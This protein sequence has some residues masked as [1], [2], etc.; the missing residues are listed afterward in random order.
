MTNLETHQSISVTGIFNECIRSFTER[1]SP[2]MSHYQFYQWMVH[3]YK[4]KTTDEV[5]FGLLGDIDRVLFGTNNLPIPAI[6]L[7]GLYI[8]N[9]CIE[10]NCGSLLGSI[11]KDRPIMI[12]YPLEPEKRHKA[13]IGSITDTTAVLRLIDTVNIKNGECVHVFPTFVEVDQIRV[14]LTDVNNDTLENYVSQSTCLTI[15]EHSWAIK[16]REINKKF[17]ITDGKAINLYVSNIEHVKSLLEK[18]ARYIFMLRLKDAD[19][20]AFRSS[21]YKCFLSLQ[22]KPLLT[23]DKVFKENPEIYEI[24]CSP[25]DDRHQAIFA[26]FNYKDSERFWQPLTRQPFLRIA[27]RENQLINSAEIRI[28]PDIV[29]SGPIKLLTRLWYRPKVNLRKSRYEGPT[30]HSS[31][32]VVPLHSINDNKQGQLLYSIASQVKITALSVDP[33]HGGSF[34]FRLLEYTTNNEEDKYINHFKFDYS[35]SSKIQFVPPLSEDYTITIPDGELLTIHFNSPSDTV[36]MILDAT[37]NII[38]LGKLEVHSPPNIGNPVKMFEIELW[39]HWNAVEIPQTA[40]SIV[41]SLPSIVACEFLFEMSC[42]YYPLQLQIYGTP[43]DSK[44][45]AVVGQELKLTVFNS[46][47]RPCYLTVMCL[48]ETGCI[49]ILIEQVKIPPPRKKEET[50]LKPFEKYIKTTLPKG[51]DSTTDVYKVIISY[52]PLRLKHLEQPMLTD[53]ASLYCYNIPPFNNQ[54]E[55]PN[56]HQ[57]YFCYQFTVQV[58]KRQAR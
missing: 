18:Y 30:A 49:Q 42:N 43:L 14:D 1:G 53:Y 16:V 45:I 40:H 38:P 36:I 58:N 57:N 37:H 5:S 15:S 19:K 46:S 10:L 39:S 13:I 33:E 28:P 7:C 26:F 44:I 6:Y 51:H 31:P 21:H 9:D 2:E 3:L 20:A 22:D 24:D 47:D 17:Q 55:L 4:E 50:E 27:F 32:L 56:N 8:S 29:P 23:T 25:F 54:V 48:E 34:S 35:P 41:S 52:S 11:D 12:S